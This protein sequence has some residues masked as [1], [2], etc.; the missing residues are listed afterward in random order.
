MSMGGWPTFCARYEQGRY[1]EAMLIFPF[2]EV[3][4]GNSFHLEEQSFVGY[5]PYYVSKVRIV[6]LIVIFLIKRL[7][8]RILHWKM[9]FKVAFFDLYE[10]N[11]Y[12]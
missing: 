1:G 10:I 4:E 8:I 3:R 2:H 6:F 5:R 9:Q 11:G 7:S 12:E